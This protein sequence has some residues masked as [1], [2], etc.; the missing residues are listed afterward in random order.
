MA[1]NGQPWQLLVDEVMSDMDELATV[2]SSK[3]EQKEA[4]PDG[5]NGLASHIIFSHKDAHFSCTCGAPVALYCTCFS[6]TLEFT[7][8]SH[9]LQ[10]TH[11]H[12][13]ANDPESFIAPPEPRICEDSRATVPTRK[14]VRVTSFH[15]KRF[16]V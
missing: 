16:P 15:P 8:E 4:I 9:C 1:S 3:F 14:E 12:G 6:G 7:P 11:S 13:D 5:D 10:Q 2:F